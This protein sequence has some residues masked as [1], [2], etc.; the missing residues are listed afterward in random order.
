MVKVIEDLG[1]WLRSFME[2]VSLLLFFL[3]MIMFYDN[4]GYG[5]IFAAGMLLLC[6]ANIITILQ[7][8]A[9]GFKKFFWRLVDLNKLP[10]NIGKHPLYKQFTGG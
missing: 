7:S 9:E 6:I 3:L 5:Y 10:T 2:N 4:G 8:D 1:Y